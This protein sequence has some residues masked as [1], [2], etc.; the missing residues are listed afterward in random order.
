MNNEGV[1]RKTRGSKS[2]KKGWKNVD[3]TDVE[4]HLE[5]VRRDERTGYSLSF[6]FFCC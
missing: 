2:R 1:K 5:D 3:I 4:Q 6:F